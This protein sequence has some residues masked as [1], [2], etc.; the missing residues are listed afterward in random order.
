MSTAISIS[1]EDIFHQLKL[2]CQIPSVIKGFM[3]RKI[4]VSTAEI[5]NI[6]V[7]PVELQQA[8]DNFR[9][10][11]K[12]KSAEQTWSWLQKHSLSLDEFEELI[13]TNIIST[14][15]SEHL[16]ADK[17]EPFF[18]EKKLD[19]LSAF[20]Y[21]IV[22]NDEDLAMEL[23]YALTEGEISF[24]EI[25]HQYIQEPELRRS[26]GYRG[27]VLRKDLKPD[28]SAAVFASKPPQILKPIVTAKGVHLILV[29][30]LVQLQLD[31]K[32]RAQ[33]LSELFSKWL[34]QQIEQV[35]VTLNFDSG[36]TTVCH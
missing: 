31:E 29:E 12:L 20:I 10:I 25:A 23:F 8:A 17:I 1:R 30:E 35:E 18:I 27:M 22:L 14:K 28:I 32:M 4:L 19:Y 6:K 9:L 2:S 3:T 15:L 7:E 5:L 36:T 16:F 34:K 11:N 21:E 13:C 24:P 33:I 26:G